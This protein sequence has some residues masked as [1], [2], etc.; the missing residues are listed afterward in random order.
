MVLVPNLYIHTTALF[1]LEVVLVLRASECIYIQ[2]C[3]YVVLVPSCFL[4]Y[5]MNFLCVTIT[6]SNHSFKFNLRISYDF[7]HC[8]AKFLHV[9]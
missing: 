5:N 1:K 6:I 9:Y 2:C 4:S 8:S 7:V 3:N